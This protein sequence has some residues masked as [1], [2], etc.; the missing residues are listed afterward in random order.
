MTYTKT[1][2]IVGITKLFKNAQFYVTTKGDLTMSLEGEFVDHTWEK[3][4]FI[5][6]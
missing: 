3:G 2:I 4:T 6:N 1:E 5:N